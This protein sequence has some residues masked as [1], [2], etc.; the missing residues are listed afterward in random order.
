MGDDD[1]KNLFGTVREEI[2]WTLSNVNDCVISGPGNRK[3]YNIKGR[4]KYRTVG[5][6]S[7]D[8]VSVDER[9]RS[10]Y[11][12]ERERYIDES[13]SKGEKPWDLRSKFRV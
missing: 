12:Q 8:T 9:T 10:V 11:L 7:W 2:L 13:H 6:A 4:V 3:R 1:H 5:E